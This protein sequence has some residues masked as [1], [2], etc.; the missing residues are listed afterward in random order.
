MRDVILFILILAFSASA[1]SFAPSSANVGAGEEVKL[2]DAQQGT[3]LKT[4]HFSSH[5][6]HDGL[7]R[8]LQSIESRCNSLET[9]LKDSEIRSEIRR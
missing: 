6:D 3:V 9:V 7:K 4:T 5:R 1:A 8:S 2:E